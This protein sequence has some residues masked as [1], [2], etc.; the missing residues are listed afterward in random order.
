MNIDCTQKITITLEGK[1]SEGNIVEIPAEDVK[2][3][4]E[5][6]VGNFANGDVVAGDN[7]GEYVFD[8]GDAGATG[9]LKCDVA[10]NGED[11]FDSVDLTL[12]PGALA[13]VKM[14][15]KPKV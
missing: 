10:I 12:E 13:S 6:V 5:N 1:D 15:L 11:F 3:S 4:Y 2:F 14:N 8:P 9:T 7:P